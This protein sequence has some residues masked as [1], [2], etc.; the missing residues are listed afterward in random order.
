MKV[1]QTVRLEPEDVEFIDRI[2]ESPN[3]RSKS[4]FMR[5]AIREKIRADKRKLRELETESHEGLLKGP[6]GPF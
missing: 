6:P 1:T 5:V 3:Y 4:E 2:C